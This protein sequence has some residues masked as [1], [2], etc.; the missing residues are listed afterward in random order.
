MEQTKHFLKKIGISLSE[1]EGVCIERGTVNYKPKD[2][3]DLEL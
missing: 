1:V 2:E 3:I